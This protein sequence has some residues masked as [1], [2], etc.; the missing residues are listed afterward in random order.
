MK[1]YKGTLENVTTILERWITFLNYAHR[2]NNNNLPKEL[3]E[4]REIRKASQKLEAMYLDEK[5]KDYYEAQQKFWLDQN[6]FMKE[7]LEKAKTEG[8]QQ[9]IQEGLQQGIQEG[10]QQGIQEGLEKGLEKGLEQGKLQ[11]KIVIAKNAIKKGLDNS[12]IAELTGLSLEEV[13]FLRT[14]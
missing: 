13:E 3:A 4:I 5:E 12:V 7:A 11:E 9:G 2:Y 14:E 6:S 1:K 10:L 8:L